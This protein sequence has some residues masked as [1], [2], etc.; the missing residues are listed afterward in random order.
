MKDLRKRVAY[1]QGLMEGMDLPNNTGEGRVLSELVGVVDDIADSI[2]ELKAEQEDLVSQVDDL[3]DGI[4]E[5]EEEVFEE[6]EDYIEVQCPHCH[7]TV[8]FASDILEDEDVIE[9]TCPNCDTVVYAN[10]DSYELTEDSGGAQM[11]RPGIAQQ[12]DI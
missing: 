1:L 10:D 3:E 2:L 6:N 8:A 12:D 7:E 4:T 5:L 9:V 11:T